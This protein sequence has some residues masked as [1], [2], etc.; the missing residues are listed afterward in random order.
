MPSWKPCMTAMRWAAARSTRACHSCGAAFLAA[1]GRNFELHGWLLLDLS[2]ACEHFS[3]SKP[4]RPTAPT[5]VRRTECMRAARGCPRLA[6]LSGPLVLRPRPERAS[7]QSRGLADRMLRGRIPDSRCRDFPGTQSLDPRLTPTAPC[8]L[9]YSAYTDWLAAMN[10]RLRLRPP[11]QRLAQRSGSA[12]RPIGLPSGAKIITPSRSAEP[13][14]QPHHRLPSTSQRMPSGV[15][16]GPASM[17]DALVGELAAAVGDVEGEELAVGHAAALDHV[18]ESSRRARST[19]R[20]ARAR[21]RRRCGL[22]RV[23]VEAIDV[24]VDLGLAL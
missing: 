17:K 19:G 21:L 18:E 23:G 1:D 24:G 20:W 3:Q 12:M 13:M 7:A 4:V 15:P 6:D 22:L 11:K 16:P 9:T 10:R 8:V 5:Q 14:P 2:C